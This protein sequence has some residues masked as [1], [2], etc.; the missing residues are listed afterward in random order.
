M[1]LYTEAYD[2]GVRMWK[3]T[4]KVHLVQELLLFECAL[5]GNPTYYWCYADEDLVGLMI[6][7]GTSCHALTV[8]ISSLTTWLV[9]CFDD[10]DDED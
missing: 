3:M 9:L 7:I 2:N 5:W 1:L 6:E 8:G 4:P 10:I